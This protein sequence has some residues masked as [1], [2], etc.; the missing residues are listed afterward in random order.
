MTPA[1][2]ASVVIGGLIIVTRA[3]LIFAPEAT[4]AFYL[5]LFDTRGRV[6]ALGVGVAILGLALVFLAASEPGLLA[7][8]LTVVG[9]LMTFAAGCLL[10]V[11]GVF[12]QL[13]E[14]LLTGIGEVGLRALG[15]LAV[16]IGGLFVYFGATAG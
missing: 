4:A 8:V 15:L 1:A 7:G 10:V 3:P 2:I 12:Q 5:R 6:R 11:P 16:G 14:A 13:A 9:G